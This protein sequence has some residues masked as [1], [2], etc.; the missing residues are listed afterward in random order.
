M[1]RVDFHDTDCYGPIFADVIV[2]I[3]GSLAFE[4]THRRRHRMHK[5]NPKIEKV[6]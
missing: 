3:F 1:L 6:R 5:V 4:L 2:Y